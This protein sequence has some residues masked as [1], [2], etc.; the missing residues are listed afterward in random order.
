MAATTIQA[1]GPADPARP[2][3]AAQGSPRRGLAAARGA[4]LLA[5]NRGGPREAY[6]GGPW[7]PVAAGPNIKR[8]RRAVR[9]PTPNRRLPQET[10]AAATCG[11]QRHRA[12]GRR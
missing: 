9:V 8:V 3:S 7:R 10:A 4:G 6:D 2:V 12:V 11:G 1:C 5:A